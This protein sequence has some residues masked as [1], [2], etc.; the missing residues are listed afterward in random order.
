MK[1]CKDLEGNDC[2][3]VEVLPDICLE[4]LRKNCRIQ[5][6]IAVDL[7]EITIGSLL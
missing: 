4:G 5:A 3:F 7:A 1:T 6:G 2:G